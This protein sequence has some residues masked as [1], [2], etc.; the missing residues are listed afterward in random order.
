[1]EAIDVVEI[2]EVLEMAGVS[3]W[4]DGGWGVDALLGMQ[5]RPHKDLDVVIDLT[6]V[7]VTSTSLAHLGFRL[8]E[9]VVG[10]FVLSDERNRPV[11]VHPVKFT[12]HG[13][14]SY[15]MEEGAVWIYPARGFRGTGSVCGRGV[16]CLTPEIQILSHAGYELGPEDI[17]DLAALHERFGVPV[18]IP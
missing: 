14:G 7:A 2:L 1:M 18:S 5:T 17:A 3:V 10:G 13:D 12:R 9:G 6:D 15:Q 8:S 11:D 16:R 4:L